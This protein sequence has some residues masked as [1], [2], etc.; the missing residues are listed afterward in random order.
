M[1]GRG[2]NDHPGL[3]VFVKKIKLYFQFRHARYH[4]PSLKII[5]VVSLGCPGDF[6]F[7]F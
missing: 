1:I 2:E 3:M 6:F 4:I 5:E 7:K